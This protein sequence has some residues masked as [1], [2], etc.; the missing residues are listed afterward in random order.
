MSAL[1]LIA[2][3]PDDKVYVSIAQ[4]VSVEA[5]GPSV[6][7]VY[8]T[9]SRGWTLQEPIAKVLERIARSRE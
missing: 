8:A 9:G 1:A 6:T 2:I 5:A 7:R 3:D 4:I